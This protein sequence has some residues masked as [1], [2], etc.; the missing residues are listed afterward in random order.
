[1]Y[2]SKCG[3]DNPDVAKFC[4]TCSSPMSLPQTGKLAAKGDQSAVSDGMK[5]GIAVASALIPIIGLI[6]GVIYLNDAN[7]EKKSA[8]KIWL[9]VACAAMVLYCMIIASS[10]Q[11]L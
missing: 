4:G 1:M 7:P 5:V 8:G 9:I 10:M 3:A 6:M 11:K 2:C